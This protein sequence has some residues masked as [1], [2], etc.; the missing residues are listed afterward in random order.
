MT[1]SDNDVLHIVIKSPTEIVW[2]GEASSLSS[3]NSEGPFDILP[4]H[5]NF[6]TLIKN[7]PISIEQY[8]SKK[9]IEFIFTYAVIFTQ[10]D[11]IS[12][13]THLEHKR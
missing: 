5:A 2:E 11:Q 7:K 6:V 8:P 1:P 13:Y 9:T 3:E 4:E 12:I 10:N